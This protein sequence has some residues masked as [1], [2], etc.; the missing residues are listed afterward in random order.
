MPVGSTC[1]DGRVGDGREAP[2]D[3]ARGVGVPLVGHVAEGHDE[4]V[5]PVLVVDEVLPEVAGLDAAE[6]HGHAAGKADGEDRLVD[7]GA[8]GDE[9]RGP[10][11]LDAR[12]H[13]LLGEPLAAVLAAHEDVEVLLLQLQG[14]LRRGLPHR[15]RRPTMAAKPGAVPSTNS[16]PLFLKMRSE[17]A[18]SQMFPSVGSSPST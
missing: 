9:A 11:D 13:E 1:G 16:T 18:P 7:V 6:G 8:E 3:G 10:A 2:V 4:G 17:A 12:L 5:G 14:D 15:A